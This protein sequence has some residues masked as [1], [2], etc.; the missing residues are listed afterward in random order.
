[1]LTITSNPTRTSPVKRGKW[2][3]DVLLDAPP[4]PPPP[5]VG[6]LPGDGASAQEL[7]MRERLDQHR[8]DPACASCHA[9]LDPLGL[10]LENYDAI[11]AWRDR[12]D[13]RPIDASGV[14]PDGAHFHGPAELV[15]LLRR[16]DAFV[17]ALTKKLMVYALGRALGPEDERALQ[18]SVYPTAKRPA[19]TLRELV[20]GIV[21]S[22]PFRTRTLPGAGG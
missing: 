18:Q 19:P 11:G 8:R 16:D 4:P 21:L 3:L 17:R 12:E 22:D 7:S 1:M 6:V 10:G 13:G 5:G 14:L 2:I 15:Q 20:R 9:R